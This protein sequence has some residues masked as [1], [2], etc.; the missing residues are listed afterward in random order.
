MRNR[1]RVAIADGNW[2]DPSIW[3]DNSVPEERD[4]VCLNQQHVILDQ[5]ITVHTLKNE[6][7]STINAFT[8]MT[9]NDE[10]EGFAEDSRGLSTAFYAFSNTGSYNY[11][12][13]VNANPV[14]ISYEFPNQEAVV[15]NQYS[16]S[17]YNT[18]HSYNPTSWDFQAWDGA[19]WVTLD[20][21]PNYGSNYY[22]YTKDLNNTTAYSKYRIYVYTTNDT[23]GMCVRYFKMNELGSYKSSS[24][25]GGDLTINNSRNIA[26]TD[27]VLDCTNYELLYCNANQGSIVNISSLI[28]NGQNKNTITING[29]GEYNFVGEVL[30]STGYGS[31]RNIA[32]QVNQPATINFTGNLNGGGHSSSH[33]IRLSSNGANLNVIGDCTG[34]AGHNSHAIGIYSASTVNITGDCFGNPSSGGGISGGALYCNNYGADITITGTVTGSTYGDTYGVRCDY[35][36]SLTITG[37]IIA[38]NGRDGLYTINVYTKNLIGTLQATNETFAV[39]SGINGSENIF[40][41]PFISSSTG[42]LPFVVG[43]LKLIPSIG[44]Y[45]QYIDNT[46]SLNTYSLVSPGAVVDS[47][48]IEDVREGTVYALGSYTGTL[49]V[50]DP[51]NVSL[52]VPVDNTVGTAILTKEDVWNVQTSELN[53]EGSIG[54][55]L[56]NASTVQSTGEQLSGFGGS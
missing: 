31:D 3:N 22:T 52:N 19:Q 6:T 2:S 36:N 14:W 28:Q 8:F 35:A 29:D 40:S 45:Y 9:M 17:A 20:S 55:R 39:Y 38:G 24:A 27:G 21:Q 30:S 26:I 1:L 41:G 49:A 13:S 16:F 37:D 12:G 51:G 44:L 10:P 56:K 34:G 23:N 32:I 54:K 25:E 53:T 15:I 48:S 11:Y 50:P 42:I 7:N 46:P 47:P 18:N 33:S 5:D 43:R 4:I